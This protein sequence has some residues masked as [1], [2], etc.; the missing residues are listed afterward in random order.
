MAVSF[1]RPSGV[2]QARS[3]CSPGAPS[4]LAILLNSVSASGNHG[5]AYSSRFSTCE[6]TADMAQS[7]Y[8]RAHRSS[9]TSHNS[10]LYGESIIL[11]SKE[12]CATPCYASLHLC[13]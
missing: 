1:A 13:I 6:S 12:S 9:K 4:S 8:V 10:Q 11:S 3:S 2:G 5:H 7:Y